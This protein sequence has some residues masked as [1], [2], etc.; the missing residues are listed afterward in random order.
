MGPSHTCRHLTFQTWANVFARLPGIGYISVAKERQQAERNALLPDW[1]ALT[2]SP[3]LYNTREPTLNILGCTD[4]AIHLNSMKYIYLHTAMLHYSSTCHVSTHVHL[5][6]SLFSVY[7]FLSFSYTFVC[8]YMLD[9]FPFSL[10]FADLSSCLPAILFSISLLA[11]LSVCVP[12]F[13]LPYHICRAMHTF[14]EQIVLF[15]ETLVLF[16]SRL[17]NWFAL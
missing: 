11:C 9:C 1:K 14:A 4:W 6:P 17:V 16:L 3:F 12:S 5:F 15:D 13:E 7:S 2:P 10:P 8:V